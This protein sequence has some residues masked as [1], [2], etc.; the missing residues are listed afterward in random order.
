M[1][2]PNSLLPLIAIIHCSQQVFHATPSISTELLWI[3]SRW[4]PNPSLSVWRGPQEYIAYEFA[5]T[6]PAGILG[7]WFMQTK[8]YYLSELLKWGLMC[9]ILCV[10]FWTVVLIFIVISWNMLWPFYP[11][12][13]LRYPLFIQA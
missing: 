2:F 13:F 1:D 9:N 3:G 7:I 11:L 5:F 12:A 4:L 8:Y 10:I 6:S